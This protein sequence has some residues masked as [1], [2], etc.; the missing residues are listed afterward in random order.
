[1]FAGTLFLVSHDRAFLE[2]TV[3]QVIAFEGNG[4]LTE[5]GGG[6]DDWR[7]FSEQRALDKQAANKA[8]ANKPAPAKPA[9]KPKSAKLSFQESKELEE[10]PERIEKLEAEQ[11]A[12]NTL[13]ADPAIYRDDPEAVKT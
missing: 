6:Y 12:I 9:E 3:T 4:V 13:L 5:F 11:S 1:D 10:L 2:N 7:R 8:A